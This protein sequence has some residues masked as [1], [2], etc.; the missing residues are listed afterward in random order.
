MRGDNDRHSLSDAIP[1]NSASYYDRNTESYSDG[2]QNPADYIDEFLEYLRQN[3]GKIILDLGS[4]PGVNAAYMHSKNFQVVGIDVSRKMIEYATSRYQDIEFQLADMTKLPFSMNSFDGI[5]A[6]F[7]LIHL[8]K[9]VIPAVLAKLHEI[10]KPGGIMYL[11]V[12]S[13]NST[14][15]F[16]SHPL[17]PSDKVFLNIFSKEE[18]FN[19]LSKSDFKVISQHEKPPQGK[20]FN[21]TKLFILAT[22][23]AR[24]GHAGS[25]A[26]L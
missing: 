5:L 26:E 7:S 22:N 23:V 15:G 8:P 24:L 25:T 18:I 9:E 3:D 16:F 12:Q 20:V 19:L 10:L 4:G 1:A 13:G 2:N 21:F 14:Q 6:S 17:I 11:S